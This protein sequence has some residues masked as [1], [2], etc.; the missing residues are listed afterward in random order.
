MTDTTAGSALDRERADL[1]ETL[2]RHRWFLR[3]TAQKLT[4][5]QG[6]TRSTA[7]ALTL[8]GLIHHVA[9]TESRWAGFIERGAEAFG[10]EAAAW[11]DPDADLDPES[12]WRLAEGETLADAL[13]HYADVAARTELVIRTVPSLDD[14][15]P[16]PV[17][18]WFEPD[19]RWSNRRVLLHILAETAQHAGHADIIRESLDGQRTMG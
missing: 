6:A 5:E 8:S 19:A 2:G 10:D 15:H 9:D 11:N 18:P 17:A 3:Y 7:S 16:L 1:I 4:D 12:R 14:E 13:A